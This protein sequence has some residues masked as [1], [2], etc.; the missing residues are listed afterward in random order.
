MSADTQPI[1]PECFASADGEVISWKGQNYIRACAPTHLLAVPEE[2]TF[3][4]FPPPPGMTP[5]EAAREVAEDA[6]RRAFISDTYENELR[7]E[8]VADAFARF[9]ELLEGEARQ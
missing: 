5:A 7:W 9:A 4:T 3:G 8:T 1:G 2:A 6:R